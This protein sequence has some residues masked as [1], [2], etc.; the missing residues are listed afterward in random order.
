MT[1]ILDNYVKNYSNHNPR[2]AAKK[3]ARKT[4]SYSRCSFAPACSHHSGSAISEILHAAA[5]LIS[6]A[7]HN[8]LRSRPPP[9]PPCKSKSPRPNPSST[10]LLVSEFTT[11]KFSMVGRAEYRFA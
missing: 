1:Q 10:S 3:C 8:W 9:N 6:V 11:E 2:Q 5:E 4:V 7:G